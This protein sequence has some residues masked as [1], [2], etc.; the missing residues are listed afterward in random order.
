MTTSLLTAPPDR[1]TAE[2]FDAIDH[3]G[4]ELVDGKLLEKGMGALSSEIQG[5]I[6]VLLKLWAKQSKLGKVYEAES[7]YR[8]FPEKPNQ[9]RKPDVSFVR[10]DRLPNKR[11]PEGVIKIAPDLAVEVISPNETAYDL[12]EKLADY[13]SVSVPLI[14]VVY[15]NLRVVDVHTLGQPIVRLTDSD[16]LTGDPV[17]PGFRV[18][19]ADLFPPPLPANV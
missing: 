17:L 5:D 13:R 14:W 7:M 4:Y 9:S 3:K 2:Q 6:L 12:E 16:E 15:P 10:L 1:M 11:S 19:V 18:R 8:C